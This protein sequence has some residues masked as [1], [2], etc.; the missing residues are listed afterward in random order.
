MSRNLEVEE[1][2]DGKYPDVQPSNENAVLHEELKTTELTMLLAGSGTISLGNQKFQP[3]ISGH[4]QVTLKKCNVSGRCFSVINM[5][6]L[7]DTEFVQK[8]DWQQLWVSLCNH[9]IHAF[10]LLVPLGQITENC[11][12]DWLLESFGARSL[13]FTI[14]VF[15]Y[16][17]A[18]EDTVMDDLKGNT[19]IEQI[20]DHCGGRYHTCHQSKNDSAMVTELLEKVEIMISGKTQCYYIKDMYNVEKADEEQQEPFTGHAETPEEET[21]ASEQGGHSSSIEDV[22]VEVK[23]ARVRAGQTESKRA[24]GPRCE[25]TDIKELLRRLQ[26]QDKLTTND[27]LQISCS[28]LLQQQ[29]RT[30]QDMP[31]AFLQRLLMMDYR[32]RYV[33]VKEENSNACSERSID[34]ARINDAPTSAFN[35]LFRKTVSDDESNKKNGIH[36]MDVQM[37]VFHCADD[38]LKQYMVTKLSQCQYALPLI[39][40]NPTTQE[41]QC[42]LWTFRQITKSWKSHGD[43]GEVTSKA[44]PISKAALPMISVFRLGS[45]S[46]SK[47]LL[48]NGLINQ[49]HNT[50]FHRHCPGN[51]Q[52]RLLMDGVVEIAWYCPSGK[53]TDNFRDCVAFCNLHGDGEENELQQKFLTKSASV[54][55]VFL[56]N[57]TQDNKAL[58]IVEELFRSSKPLICLLD[59]DDSAITDMSE[60]KYKIGLKNRNQSD[61]FKDLIKSIRESLSKPHQA[62]KL[63][64]ALQTSG[65]KV[66]EDNEDCKK[67]K[68]C[69]L[70]LLE[71]LK[72]TKLFKI[73]E[74]F[75]PCQGKLWQD[76]SQKNKDLYRLHGDIEKHK[77]KVEQ[78]MRTIRRKQR[79]CGLSNLMESFINNLATLNSNQRAYFLKWLGILMDNHSSGTLLDLQ[80]KYDQKWSSLLALKKDRATSKKLEM[81]Q[82]ELETISEELN[83]ATFGIE[84]FL[85]EIGQ[86]YEAWRGQK[87]QITIKG[88]MRNIS[89]LPELA[90]KLMISG[91]PLEL[92]D[93]DAAHVPLNWIDAVLNE[94]IKQLGDKRI[95]VLSVLG[96]QSTGKSTMLN[97]MFGLQFAVSAGRCTRGAFMQ[98]V[99]LNEDM[100]MQQSYDYVLVVDTEGLR[101]LELAGKE[102]LHHDNELATF[103]IGLGDTTL[104]NIFGENPAEM[105]D[106]LQIAVQAFLRMKKV[107][108]SPRCVFVHQ[109]VGDITASEKNMEGKRRL[110]EKLDKM[111]QLAAKEEECDVES[112]SDVIAFD[113]TRDVKYFAQLWEG[114]PPMAPPNPCYSENIQDLKQTIF[115]H[116]SKLQ[117]KGKTVSHFKTRIHDLW[118]ALLNENFVFSFKNTLEIAVYRQLETEY[119]KWTWTLRRAMLVTE[120]KLHNRIE[121]ET[122]DM[123]LEAFLVEELMESYEQVKKMMNQY[124]EE[125]QDKEV[126]VQWKG[127]FLCKIRELH[128]DLVKGTKRKFDEVIQQREACKKVDEKRRQYENELFNKSKELALKLKDMSNE[129]ESKK[130]FDSMWAEWVSELTQGKTPIKSI[131]VGDDVL[132]ILSEDNESSLVHSQKKSASYKNILC[133]GNYSPY[134]SL[135]KPDDLCDR[136]EHSVKQDQERNV[137]AAWFQNAF[138][139]VTDL[140]SV[141]NNTNLES[142]TSNNGLTP[143]DQ[144]R[145]RRLLNDVAKEME[146]YINNTPVSTMGY[147]DSY[148]QEIQ[149]A[150]TRKVKEFESKHQKLLLKKELI[151]N[152]LLYVCEMAER[153]FT[154]FHME[155]KEKNDVEMY[156]ASMK[157][158]YYSIFKSY[159]QGATS[160]AVFAEFICTKLKESIYQAVCD[161][162][163]IDIAGEMRASFPAFSGNRSG[164]EVHILR[165][166]AEGENFDKFMEYI[167]TPEKHFKN[168]I[169]HNVKMYLRAKNSSKILPLIKINIKQKHQSL[170]H[171][172]NTATAETKQSKG[173][174]NMWLKVFSRQLT[175][176]LRFAENDIKGMNHQ[177]ITDFGFLQEVMERSLGT[178]IEQVE[179]N[180]TSKFS[181]SLRKFREGPDKILIKQLCECCWVQ[182]PFCKAI[183]TNTVKGHDG[184]HQVPFHH[185]NGI[186]GWIYRGTD[187]L[188]IEFCTTAVASDKRF[189]PSHTCRD[190][191]LCLYKQYK[192]AGPR[193]ACWSITPDNSELPYWKWFVC[194]FQS[195][196]EKYYNRKFHGHGE[197]PQ[198]WRAFTK[199]QALRSLDNL[200]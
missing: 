171:A 175:D 118:N 169:K 110:Q 60:G 142:P 113:V 6:G 105:Q 78:D 31:Y 126:L 145:I 35:A 108:L 166:L 181:I 133:L 49:R 139:K 125:S 170:L 128:D 85:R 131:T 138:K 187:N 42:P 112:F 4:P 11:G 68:A 167:H 57:L 13:E 136:D 122:F 7:R 80:R 90:A 143:E 73:K 43:S 127:R 81:N 111:T 69:A 29:P 99:E 107:K 70:D 106:I 162:T 140:I 33:T 115:S 93:G 41:I 95:F 44:M 5:L 51:S 163:A 46:T 119:G 130:E 59:D 21:P 182:C 153:K 28:S 120:N 87:D 168:F 172:T 134:I 157:P 165:S 192:Q 186:N 20:L 173:D 97:A 9:E 19:V 65:F 40:I 92:M 27:F 189:Y 116:T 117:K 185:T 23:D 141:K 177:D 24:E 72:E 10:L 104:I 61:I 34:K 77:S 63:E 88:E 45:V 183:C 197:I 148:I 164:M 62:F 146:A 123:M 48:L 38:F 195:D 2:A 114:S 144:D 12:L 55:V 66:D 129:E 109:N 74:E 184:D 98:L 150:V 56:P 101:A 178:V 200:I 180:F 71:Q 67:G 194:R 14:I 161:K 91:Y 179:E 53:D 176:E 149:H 3:E 22:T 76:W 52:K 58:V 100:K 196:L 17:D 151:I 8:V 54:N 154:E 193:Y 155:F 198:E 1:M 79:D 18:Q 82:Q 132:R 36:P 96:V 174:V 102:T 25:D 86:I 188:C 135:K 47:S 160:A 158:Q 39:V 137:F 84:H 64:D 156:L 199:E 152:I 30:E 32:A 147:N 159:C 75:L 94:V 124:F 89:L 190:K 16:D 121:N 37:A 191:D 103:V 50:F 26:L 83:A 15:T